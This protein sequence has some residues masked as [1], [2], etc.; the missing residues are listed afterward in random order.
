MK[1]NTIFDEKEYL[2]RV[3]AL[4]LTNFCSLIHRPQSVRVV[5]EH[6]VH[7]H[8]LLVLF[9]VQGQRLQVQFAGV[10][11]DTSLG[12]P[13][14]W[15][16]EEGLTGVAERTVGDGLA[17]LESL[18][19]HRALLSVLHTFLQT[20]PTEAVGTKQQH[21]VAEDFPTHGALEVLL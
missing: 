17:F 14:V 19:T 2:E 12:R 13:T 21:R 4:Y 5:K 3:V 11:S 18:P 1:Q 10:L 8:G 9:T 6:A 16:F 7:A 15:I 20:F